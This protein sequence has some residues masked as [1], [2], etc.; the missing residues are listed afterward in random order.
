MKTY[1]A[2][3]IYIT[4]FSAIY[5]AIITP[6]CKMCQVLGLFYGIIHKMT[7]VKCTKNIPERGECYAQIFKNT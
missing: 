6:I 1:Q 2:I 7:F 3:F 4:P 5:N